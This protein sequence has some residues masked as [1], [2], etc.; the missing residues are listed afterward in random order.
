[1]R[2]S[3]A[4]DTDVRD[5][6]AMR[7]GSHPCMRCLVVGAAWTWPQLPSLVF[8]LECS[9]QH[10]HTPDAMQLLGKALAECNTHDKK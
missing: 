4:Q 1:M 3:N 7:G 6:D 2:G 9:S 5:T 10:L 8:G